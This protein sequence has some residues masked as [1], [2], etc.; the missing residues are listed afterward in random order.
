MSLFSYGGTYYHQTSD[1]R[2][3]KLSEL[4][5]PHLFNILNTE[6][7]SIDKTV[8]EEELQHRLSSNSKSTVLEQTKFALLVKFS[9]D[10]SS[11]LDQEDALKL[12]ILRTIAAEFTARGLPFQNYSVHL[13]PRKI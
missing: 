4:A 5:T 1:K 10:N 2:L 9:S 12:D 6:I 7:D 13:N 11:I 3:I 8:Y